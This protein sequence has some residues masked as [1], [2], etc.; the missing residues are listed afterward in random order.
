MGSPAGAWS[1]GEKD[2]LAQLRSA[3]DDKRRL[4]EARTLASA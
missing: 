2:M 4:S 3:L 1:Q